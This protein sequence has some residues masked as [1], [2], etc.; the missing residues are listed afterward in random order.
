[1]TTE[2]TDRLKGDASSSSSPE[3]LQ[4]AASGVVQ[5]AG[6]AAETQASRAMDRAGDALEQVARALRDTS[7]SLRQERPE[8]AGIA[9]TGAQRVDEVGLY[10]R[11]HDIREVV[12]EAERFARRQPALV[13]GGGLAVGLILG[14]I[15]RSG[16]EPQPGS[17]GYGTYG[18]RS[19]TGSGWTGG[20]AGSSSIPGSGYGTS[21]GT[22]YDTSRTAQNLARTD[23]VAEG[24]NGSSAS[25]TGSSSKSTSRSSTTGTS[26]TGTKS[27]S[28]KSGTG[29]T[30]S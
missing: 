11:Q 29:S 6:Q 7:N 27:R 30:G 12:E 15:L 19:L 26:S 4:E 14:R 3:K 2:Q 1:M 5:S 24:S 13:L 25:G 9:E 21:Y 20:T 17:G 23:A 18:Q 22:T 8:I 28:T 10:L 16:A